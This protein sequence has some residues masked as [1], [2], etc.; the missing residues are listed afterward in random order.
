MADQWKARVITIAGKP[1]AIVDVLVKRTIFVDAN[2]MERIAHLLQSEHD[3]D[4]GKSGLGAV[5]DFYKDIQTV[6]KQMR[7]FVVVPWTA[8]DSDKIG[9][10]PF[11]EI[12]KLLENESYW[13][14]EGNVD[15]GFRGILNF[16]GQD[17]V[18]DIS[19]S[20][21]ASVQTEMTR[22]TTEA[23]KD[24]ASGELTQKD[25]ETIDRVCGIVGR[26]TLECVRFIREQRQI[27]EQNDREKREKDAAELRQQVSDKTGQA[28]PGERNRVVGD[29]MSGFGEP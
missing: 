1:V 21:A 7:P 9:L 28:D 13:R 18:I 17:R 29:R 5:A 6:P 23:A 16:G 11:A 19:E 22:I 27:R 15:D 20:S 26:D 25:R 2:A 14:I 12:L 3:N 4:Y 24:V 8:A 10:R